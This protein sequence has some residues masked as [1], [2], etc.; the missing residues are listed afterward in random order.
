MATKVGLG[1]EV[2][3]GS[4]LPISRER[5]GPGPSSPGGEWAAEAGENGHAVPLSGEEWGWVKGTRVVGAGGWSCSGPYCALKLHE[6]GVG[7]QSLGATNEPACLSLEASPPSLTLSG[8]ESCLFQTG[9][10][11]SPI[12]S[13]THPSA[14]PH[15]CQMTVQYSTAWRQ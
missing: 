10:W 5:P 1:L 14:S 12:S 9:C 3:V 6:M 8:Q 2:G 4:C 11:H 15:W 13:S 7:D